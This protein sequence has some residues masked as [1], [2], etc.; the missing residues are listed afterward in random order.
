MKN[1]Q[2]GIREE[3]FKHEA[4]RGNVGF[5]NSIPKEDRKPIRASFSTLPALTSCGGAKPWS[6]WR[7]ASEALNC[8]SVT[9]WHRKV[10]KISSEV[11]RGRPYWKRR[12]LHLCYSFLCRYVFFQADRQVMRRHSARGS[13]PKPQTRSVLP[14][15]PW[16]YLSYSIRTR[17][18]YSDWTKTLLRKGSGTLLWFLGPESSQLTALLSLHCPWRV[19]LPLCTLESGL[20]QTSVLFSLHERPSQDTR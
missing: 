3:R 7:N 1:D 19:S 5:S 6:Y 20:F 13:Q 10:D 16:R 11:T 4:L 17:W 9:V 2:Q 8:W 14:L 15:L 12:S 18:V